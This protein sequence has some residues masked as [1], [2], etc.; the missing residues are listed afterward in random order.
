MNTITESNVHKAETAAPPP[1]HKSPS[2]ST[3]LWVWLLLVVIV[4]GAG[5][6]YLQRRAKAQSTTRVRPS[7][8]PAAVPIVTDTVKKGD[9]GVYINALG[10]VTPVY[11][12]TVTSRVTGQIMDVKYQEGQMVHKGDPLLLID[13]RPYQVQLAQAEGQ[14]QHDL[15]LLQEAR[16]DLDRYKAAYARNAIPKQQLDDQEQIVLQDEG[17]VKNDQAAIDNAKL[18]LVYCNITSPIDG[19]VGLRLVDPGNMV[20]ANGTSGLVVVTQ[21]EPITVIFNVAE[22][23]LG[24][25]EQQLR[26]GHHM[27]VDAFD[28][29]Q[30]KKI[31]TGSLL[32][33]DNQIDPTT[34]TVKLRALFANKEDTLFPN[35]FVNASLLIETK[36]NA[37]LVPTAAIQRNAQT[38]FLYVITPQETASMRNVTVGTTDGNVSEVQ[39]VQPGDVVAVNGFDKLQDGIKVSARNEAGEPAR[40]ARA[41]GD[42]GANRGEGQ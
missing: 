25:I 22:D 18:Q 10:T 19:R 40:S 17:T 23:Y 37:T 8:L 38:A 36:H 6:F 12:V 27:T 5:F 41:G 29:T 3:R 32:T 33:L 20:Q 42:N 35:Q 16:I 21:L 34:G 39:G 11:T 30:Q 26:A 24:D 31:A 2:G 14:Y 7:R 15:G 13:P 9:I 28:R 4:V 1:D